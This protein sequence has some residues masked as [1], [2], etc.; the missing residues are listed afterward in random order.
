[1]PLLPARVLPGD[2]VAVVS[3]SSWPESRDAVDALLGTLQSWGLQPEVSAHIADRRGYMAGTD[4]DRL[5]DLNRALRDPGVRAVIASRGGCGALR[6]IRGVDRQA[7]QRDPKPLVGYSDIT[8]LHQVWRRARVP[9]VHGAVAGAHRDVF[10]A[11]LLDGASTVVQ[12]DPRMITAELTTSGRARGDLVGGNL[13]LLARSVG[14]V[15]VFWKGCIL[16][17]EANKAAGLGMVDRALTQLRLSGALDHITAIALGSFDEF[18]GYRD[19]GWTITETLHDLLDDL[20]VP[21]LGGL[22]I[23]HIDS[24]VPVP[25]GVPA[26]LDADARRLTV[27]PAVQ[28]PTACR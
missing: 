14:V 24:P 21:I 10:R 6:L 5:A 3:P 17:L 12:T 15:E 28:P 2:R 22:P 18:A 8:A 9:A 4:A 7:L 23:G 20:R 16:L 1:M 27:E 26:E 25:L 13:E 11:Q 19:R